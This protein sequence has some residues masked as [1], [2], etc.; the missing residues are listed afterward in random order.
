MKYG[1]SDKQLG[2]VLE[3]LGLFPEIEVAVLF[4][5]R[6]MENYKKA[7]DIDIALKGKQIDQA[8]AAK[9]KVC[10]EEDTYL[11]FFVDVLAYDDLST[12]KLKD[13]IDEHGIVLYQK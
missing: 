5:S 6:A 2:I 4:G 3:T 12:E 13:Q 8:F 1:L 9:V 10:F 11:P 7:S